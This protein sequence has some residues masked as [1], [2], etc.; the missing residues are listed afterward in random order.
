[1][2]IQCLP[3]SNEEVLSGPTGSVG[4]VTVTFPI[5]Q[6]ENP[7]GGGAEGT[8]RRARRCNVLN[9]ESLKQLFAVDQMILINWVWYCL[10]YTHLLA[11]S[12]LSSTMF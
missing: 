12:L 4:G 3:P 10:Y 11:P 1:M 8:A 9:E 5:A 7:V 2:L 6:A